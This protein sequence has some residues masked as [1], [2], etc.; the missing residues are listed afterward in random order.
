MSEKK[1]K[2]VAFYREHPTVMA[3]AEEIDRSHKKKIEDSKFHQKALEKI[4]QEASKEGGELW[5]K[6]NAELVRLGLVEQQEVD[7][8]HFHLDVDTMTIQRCSG[9]HML[10]SL[11]Q[12]I[13][14]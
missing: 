7:N 1:P 14:L 13:E 6:L 9:H 5:A 3:L 12:G 8:S 4:R 11:L 2:V 10:A